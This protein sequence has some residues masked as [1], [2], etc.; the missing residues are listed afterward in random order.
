M[1]L[2]RSHYDLLFPMLA[3]R[4]TARHVPPVFPRTDDQ[5]HD[6]EI[7]LELATRLLAP[8]FLRRPVRALFGWK[9]PEGMVDLGLRLGPHGRRRGGLSL[10]RLRREPHGVDL[11]PLEPRFPKRLQMKDK[12]IKLAPAEFVGDVPRLR[13]RM[14]DW[15][16]TN[17]DRGLVLIG[18]RHLRSNNSWMHNSDRLMSGEERCTLQ[19]HPAAAAARAH[20]GGDT[21]TV[22]SAAGSIDVPV[23]VTDEV[24]PGVVS[25]PHGFGHG[26][27]GVQLR[28]AAAHAGAS[29]N[30]ITD[31]HFL[32]ALCGT[33]ALSGVPVQVTAVAV[34]RPDA[35]V[36]APS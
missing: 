25:M 19:M 2:E 8:G 36:G 27:P 17:G 20:A 29:A 1:Q 13:E 16:R 6:W 34:V 9:G 3:V 22:T 35:S 31:E 10:A 26:R 33:A 12:T 15:P 21:V 5:R 24:M 30:D 32:D 23:D 7:C 18:R 4:N 28:V 11:G 14:V